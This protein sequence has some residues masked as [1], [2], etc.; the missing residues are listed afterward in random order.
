MKHRWHKIRFR[1]RPLFWKTIRT[2]PTPPSKF[3]QHC[4]AEYTSQL[5]PGWPRRALQRF[6]PYG[7]AR[8]VKI[9][10]MPA[11]EGLP[12]NYVPPMG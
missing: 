12:S 5:L 10:R 3:C 4:G 9:E 7:A 2:K 8:L 6:R 11:C 1:W